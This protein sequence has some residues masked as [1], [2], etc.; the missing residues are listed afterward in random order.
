MNGIE[1]IQGS[2]DVL[3]GESVYPED[4]LEN[5]CQTEC[6]ASHNGRETFLVQRN[7]DGKKGI[8]TCYD[9]S[10]YPFS[11]D[12]RLL[13]ELDHPGLPH[14]YKQFEN[15]QMVCIVREYIEGD[16]LN[17]YAAKKQ[18]T[19]QEIVDISKQLCDIL[20]VLHDHEPQ[21][22][23]RDIKPENIIVKP[24]GR[25]VLIDFDIARTFKEGEE[26]DT[27]FFGTKVY[28]PPEQYGFGQTDSRADI[29]S[30]GVLLRWLV[31]GNARK[32]PN[33]TATPEIEKIIER[34][35][36][37]DPNRRYNRI[38]EVRRALDCVFS[39]KKNNKL[40]TVICSVL[41]AAVALAAGFLLG[42]LTPADNAY[43]AVVFNEPLIEQAVRAAIGK[44]EGEL[45]GE[46]ISKVNKLYIYGDRVFNDPDEFYKCTIE[47]S[48]QGSIRS[49]DDIK[50][51]TGLN[52]MRIVNQGFV[53]ATGVAGHGT[54]ECVELKHMKL[55]NPAAIA[56]I[57]N[58]K[59]AELFDAGLTDVTMFQKCPWLEV[60]N[61]GHNDIN[62]LEQVGRS[63]GLRYIWLS[64]LKMDDVDD[65]AERFP[66]L[67]LIGIGHSQINDMSGL[68]KLEK[69]EKIDV[70]EEQADAVA[71]LF[72]GR[73]IKINIVT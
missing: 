56:N 9:R 61:L 36:A 72:K 27:V 37:F 54:L 41:V 65:I 16:T 1:T 60:L 30:F 13:G 46:D 3:F 52:E 55:S 71:A 73:N 34:C 38:S 66:N 6:L 51:L 4:F 35:T 17:A 11:T 69:L 44:E 8:A 33:I 67:E 68:L 15:G 32:N 12:I 25:I 22:V 57:P 23:H 5:Y 26:T 29:Y 20:E 59:S 47:T 45:T 39:R 21:I 31:T 50:K 40:K 7:S 70:L 18:I 62:S 63:S 10:K 58:L 53:D 2:M 42:R 19:L 49:L 48:T 64:F 28:A 14:Y 24:D 43:D